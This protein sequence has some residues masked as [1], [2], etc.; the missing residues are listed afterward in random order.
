MGFTLNELSF[1]ISDTT[2]AR[3]KRT[4]VWFTKLWNDRYSVYERLYGMEGCQKNSAIFD[5]LK[6]QWKWF[7]SNVEDIRSYSMAQ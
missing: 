1:A 4:H 3:V 5:A 6:N 2:L 7:R